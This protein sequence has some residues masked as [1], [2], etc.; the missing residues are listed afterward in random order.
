[1][2]HTMLDKFICPENENGEY[3]GYH[4]VQWNGGGWYKGHFVNDVEYGYFQTVWHGGGELNKE[5][6]AR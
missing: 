5:Y 4:D 2:Y 3:H 6:Y 1:M